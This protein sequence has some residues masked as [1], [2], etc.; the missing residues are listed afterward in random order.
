ML[1]TIGVGTGMI[2]NDK[3][4]FHIHTYRCGHAEN[5]SDEE[6]IKAAIQCGANSIWFSDHAPFPGD[7][8][9]GRMKYDELGEY[10][11]SILELRHK[12]RNAI[13]VRIGLETEYFPSFDRE[14]YYQKLKTSP[15]LDFLLLGQHMAEDP[16]RKT[17]YTFAWD[18]GKLDTEEYLALGNAIVQGI[19]SGHFDA[20]AHPDRIFRRCRTWTSAMEQVS[21][22]IIHAAYTQGMPLELNINS[23]NMKYQYWLEFWQLAEANTRIIGLDA[24]GK[25]ELLRRYAKQQQIVS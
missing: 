16:E 12:Y 1:T 15:H 6:Y 11:C 4:I 5:I 7:P 20:V 21:S 3:D 8:F 19:Q 25:D 9:Q 14:G 10:F 17:G 2:L 23:V 24:H 13:D 18:E 22:K